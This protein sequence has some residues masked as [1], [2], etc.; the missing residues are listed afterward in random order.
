MAVTLALKPI[1]T[2]DVIAV[3]LHGMRVDTATFD[4]ELWRLD[5][6]ELFTTLPDAVDYITD[7]VLA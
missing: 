4:G 3:T 5:Q 1:T 7:C 6:G 2:T